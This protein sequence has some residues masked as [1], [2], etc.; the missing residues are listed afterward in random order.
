MRQESSRVMQTI[1][2]QRRRPSRF[3]AVGPVLLTNWRSPQ[4]RETI[5]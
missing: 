5:L 3:L 2:A 1:P 4:K